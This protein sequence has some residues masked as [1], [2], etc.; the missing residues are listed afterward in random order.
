[1]NKWKI[2][3]RIWLSAES[4]SLSARELLQF[5]H[6]FAPGPAHTK[7]LWSKFILPESTFSTSFSKW[8][9]WLV[10]LE[11]IAFSCCFRY[12]SRC[13]PL[14]S[15]FGSCSTCC[16]ILVFVSTH[17]LSFARCVAHWSLLF[18]TLTICNLRSR[19]T[20]TGLPN[21]PSS[22]VIWLMGTSVN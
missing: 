2:K 3:K 17:S 20:E 15:E 16:S 5:A 14:E 8:F 18:E 6:N 4:A 21:C 11:W 9:I 12:C 19:G 1:M 13:S 7:N 10:N 22:T